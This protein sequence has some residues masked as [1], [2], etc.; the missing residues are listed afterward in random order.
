MV[1]ANGT[2]LPKIS[3]NSCRLF[4]PAARLLRLRWMSPW[5]VLS[6]APDIDL[7]VGGGCQ[8]AFATGLDAGLSEL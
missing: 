4:V 6:I 1:W 7:F 3:P 8:K 5:A 2:M